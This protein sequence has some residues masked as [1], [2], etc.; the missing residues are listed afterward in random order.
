VANVFLE[1]TKE[2]T[3]Q[4]FVALDNNVPLSLLRANPHCISKDQ[5]TQSY[6]ELVS[7]G[8]NF[9]FNHFGSLNSDLLLNKF[10]YYV[11]VLK[12]DYIFLDHLS[13]VVSDGDEGDNERKILDKICTKLAAFCTETGVGIIMVVHLRKSAVG[14][15]SNSQG[16]M[17]TLDDLR[18]SG[19]IA[20]LSWNVI[21]LMRDT[22]ASDGLQN[23]TKVWVLK[24]REIGTLGNAGTL[25]YNTLTGRMEDMEDF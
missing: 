4:A 5:Y 22:T 10:R 1:E 24:N 6:E 14:S 21:A 23:Q 2:K 16:G 13:M 19:G 25:L 9:F 11:N 12:V 3:A 18:G 7:N 8:R 15:Q 17:I 20:Q